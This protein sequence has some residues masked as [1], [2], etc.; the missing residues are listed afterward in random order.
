MEQRENGIGDSCGS[1]AELDGGGL[2]GRGYIFLR[3]LPPKLH[4]VSNLFLNEVF[5]IIAEKRDLSLQVP[6]D[7]A[8]SLGFEHEVFR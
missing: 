2:W 4:Q 8:I 5:C 6:A 3:G 7:P 1:C